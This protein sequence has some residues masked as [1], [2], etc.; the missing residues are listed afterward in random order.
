MNKRTLLDI[1]DSEMEK[2]ERSCKDQKHALTFKKSKE[3]HQR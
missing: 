3:R 2:E 1:R